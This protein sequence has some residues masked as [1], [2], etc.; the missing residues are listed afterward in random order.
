MKKNTDH[1]RWLAFILPKLLNPIR[2]SKTYSR[3]YDKDQNCRMRKEQ[4]ARQA[5][6]ALASLSQTNLSI[7]EC[8]ESDRV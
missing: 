5:T 8:E 3:K 4:I 7:S 2:L 1:S 6:A